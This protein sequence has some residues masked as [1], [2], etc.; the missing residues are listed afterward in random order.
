[1][2]LQIAKQFYDDIMANLLSVGMDTRLKDEEGEEHK[3]IFKSKN[4]CII[5]HRD[6]VYS[7]AEGENKMLVLDL[8]LSSGHRASNIWP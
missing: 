1:M 8:M 7:V 6:Y 2:K 5:G 4:H 3:V